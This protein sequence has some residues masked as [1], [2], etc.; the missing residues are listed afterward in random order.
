MAG[1]ALNRELKKKL[2]FLQDELSRPE[3]VTRKTEELHRLRVALKE[4]ACDDLLVVM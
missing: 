1:P 4:V 3:S 2:Q